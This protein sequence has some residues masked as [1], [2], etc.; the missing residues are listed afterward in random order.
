MVVWSSPA[1]PA[2]YQPEVVFGINGVQ[3]FVQRRLETSSDDDLDGIIY[4]A[5]VTSR[6]E[7]A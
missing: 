5:P 2:F 7:A 6:A 3:H 1:E 4:A